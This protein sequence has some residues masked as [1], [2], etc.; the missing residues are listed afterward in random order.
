MRSTPQRAKSA[1]NVAGSARKQ[2]DTALSL[3]I[4]IPVYNEAAHLRACLDAIAVQTVKPSEVIVVDNNSTDSS[5]EIAESFPF[6]RVIKEKK[7]GIVYARD[8]GFNA[9][10]SDII[11]RIDG[12]TRLPRNWVEKVH[13]FYKDGKNRQYAL[14]GG[15]YFYNVRAP[16]FNGWVQS[17][18]AYRVNRF[19]V[20][21]YILWGSNMAF[22][23]EQW[24]AVRTKVCHDVF[25]H[26]DL[27]L[28]IHLHQLGC[29]IRYRTDL[30]AGVYLK[31]IYEN[32]NEQH[33]H[34]QRWPK[35]LHSHHFPLWWL[36]I[37]GNILLKYLV[38]PFVFVT[39]YAARAIG[40]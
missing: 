29:K 16:R 37:S 4:V 24:Q 8:A 23:R 34:L 11:G 25:I 31:R 39:E 27:D 21:F 38:Q 13:N 6:V 5:Q 28:A 12:D 14:T 7:Q 18:L 9:A 3:S 26:E 20:G 33:E 19:I 2:D 10:T 36:S 40:R 22:T 1:N 15:G 35:T 30:K 32:R 17:Q